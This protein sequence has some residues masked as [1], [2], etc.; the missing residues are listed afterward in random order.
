MWVMDGVARADKA[1]S[2]DLAS[3]WRPRGSAFVPCVLKAEEGASA[4]A[5]AEKPEPS[6]LIVR[7]PVSF[8]CFSVLCEN[9]FD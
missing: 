2:T 6:R 8:L 3:E 4:A 9:K 1:P 5:A 7:K